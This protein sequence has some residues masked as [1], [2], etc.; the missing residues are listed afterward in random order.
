L[1]AAGGLVR[2]EFYEPPYTTVNVGTIV[3]GTAKNIVPGRCEFL[4]EW[5]PVAGADTVL[6]E[7]ER[8]VAEVRGCECRV[9]VLRLQVGFETAADAGLVR[10]MEEAAGRGSMAIPFGSE[11]SV[12]AAVAEEIVV[13]GA[14]DMRTA[15]SERECVPVAELD[16]AVR[17]LA[18]LMAR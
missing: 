12:F 8:M 1:Q 10:Q 13:F 11:A 16:D 14:G 5:R 9:E 2:D 15:H 4:V 17:V 6:E 3:G 18:G 7:L